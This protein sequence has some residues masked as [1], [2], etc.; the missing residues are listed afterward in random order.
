MSEDV[1]NGDACLLVLVKHAINEV[2]GVLRQVSPDV[3]V[4]L[5]LLRYDVLRGYA[6][7]VGQEG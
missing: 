6:L 2:L 4:E 7:V 5:Q 1:A 3:G